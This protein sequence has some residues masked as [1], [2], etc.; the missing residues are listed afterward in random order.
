MLVEFDAHEACMETGLQNSCSWVGKGIE[1]ERD[2]IK[3]ILD[4]RQHTVIE[5]I[6]TIRIVTVPRWFVRVPVGFSPKSHQCE[7][8]GAQ[9]CAKKCAL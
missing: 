9:D 6:T 1:N 7:R 3:T 5:H 4:N 8:G 2:I